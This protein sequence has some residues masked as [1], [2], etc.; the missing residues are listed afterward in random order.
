MNKLLA[1]LLAG[2][3][4][5]TLSIGAFAADEM[6]A[7]EAAAPAADAAPAPIK[8][9]HMHKAHK[10]HKKMEKAAVATPAAAPEAAK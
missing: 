7:P 8:A 3:F 2:V 5:A 6:A 4:A 1:A 10:S 9:K